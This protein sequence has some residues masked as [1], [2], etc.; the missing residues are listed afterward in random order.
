MHRAFL[1]P[2]GVAA[3]ATAACVD[4]PRS[5]VAPPSDVEAFTD[6]LN[7]NSNP[8]Y[9]KSA[10]D[11]YLDP[12]PTLA[13]HFKIAG[14]GSGVTVNVTAAALAH[15]TDACVNGGDNVPSDAKKT[16]SV[17]QVSFT[18]PVT[19]TAGGNVEATFHLA[20]P[21]SI[22][23]CPNGQTATRFEAFWDAVGSSVASPSI[24]IGI[25]GTF[26]VQ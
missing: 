24:S 13:V 14:V 20:F 11:A 6:V 21:A 9:I 10:T 26:L 18:A 16:K 17:Q 1:F 25:P 8:H 23:S 15:R 19:A 12:S 5:P 22:L 7:A 2:L 4:Q 3:L